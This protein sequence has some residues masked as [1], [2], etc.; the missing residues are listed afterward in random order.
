MRRAQSFVP[1]LSLALIGTLALS[2]HAQTRADCERDYT[3]QRA[4]EGKDV[5]WEPTEDEMVVPMLEM[6]RLTAGDTLYD[7]GAGDGKIPI[8]AAKLYG[9]KAVGIE[10]D[11]DLA[12]FGQCLAEAAGVADRVSIVQGD[13][14]EADFSDATVVALYLLPELNLRLRPT[15][16]DMPPGTRIVSY[17]FTMGD[18]EPDDRV[19]SHSA[20]SAYFW[21]VP[22]QIGGT[23][24][25]RAENG[26]P[27]FEF[28]LEQTFQRLRAPGGDRSI[29]GRL[30]G[31]GVEIEFTRGGEAAHLAGIVDA[32]GDGM[33]A[34]V[35]HGG[36]PMRYRGT[37]R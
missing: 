31:R 3:P 18:W 12:K 36:E 6:A 27:P 28:E 19:E 2:V 9:A 4:Q 8:A 24:T 17:S 25:F 14:F 16:L 29:V 13:I 37:R 5:I 32:A 22:A 33:E 34:V 10:Y 20:G 1:A 30:T 7:L 35:T 26:G 11:A 23:W 15:L 21:M